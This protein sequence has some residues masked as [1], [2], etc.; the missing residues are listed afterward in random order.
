VRQRKPPRRKSSDLRTRAEARLA[1][2][3][4]SPAERISATEARRLLHDLE[5]HQVELELQNEELRKSR[6]EV[7]LG[8]QRYSELFDFAPIGYAVLGSDETIL[9]VN[10]AGAHLLGRARSLLNRRGFA[11]LVALRDRSSLAAVLRMVRNGSAKAS[12]EV[13][14]NVE[15]EPRT[16]VRLTASMLTRPDP[17]FLLAFADITAE[18]RKTVELA[19]A[20]RALRE[21]D[22]RKDEFLAMLSHELRNPLTPIRSS[23]YA[24]DHGQPDAAMARKA[25]ETIERQVTHLTRII[26]DLLDVTRI[27]RGKIRLTRTRFDLGALVKSVIDDH[28]AA[29]EEK[30]VSLEACAPSGTL[31]VDADP[32]RIIQV[33]S[34]LLGNAR[35]FTPQG[36]RVEVRV[37]KVGARVEVRVC[38]NGAGIASELLGHMF[39]PFHQA[40]QTL[41]RSTGGLGLGLAMVKG[42]VELHGGTAEIASSG[43]D[44]GTQVT[45]RLP[46]ADGPQPVIAVP[47]PLPALRRRVVLIED[48]R[49]TA[50]G[51]HTVLRMRGHE[52][53]V[54]YDGPTGIETVRA[55]HPEVVICDLGLP[56]IDGYSLA[57]ILRGDKS[58]APLFLVSLSGYAQPEDVRRATAAGFDRHIAKPP[59][60]DVL[61]RL[62]A[63]APG[64]QFRAVRPSEGLH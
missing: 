15:V 1:K 41:D 20:E 29:F 3:S 48:N 27:R 18:R 49:D 10:H 2:P 21:E 61:A 55:F 16:V 19:E 38:D 60:L 5:V 51:L 9:A 6:Q 58:L 32:T 17:T 40:P 63:E 28:R 34:N 37:Q 23:L 64:V 52:V 36:G 11:S 47:G 4:R 57:T 53:R 59:D 56:G 35:K 24:L 54:A 14:L 45:L 43:L 31:R 50:D 30:G 62:V 25:R 8:L 22:A 26:D 39:E 44:R 46:L 42:L 13:E 7:E 12:C 33:L